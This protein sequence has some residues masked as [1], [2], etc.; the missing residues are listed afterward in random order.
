MAILV[1]VRPGVTPLELLGF[2]EKV[3]F[4]Y[5]IEAQRRA[6]YRDRFA[7]VRQVECAHKT[8]PRGGLLGYKGQILGLLVFGVVAVSRFG[9]F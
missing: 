6:Q 5:L 1:M 7:F 8:K 9:G 2:C 3:F 4:F